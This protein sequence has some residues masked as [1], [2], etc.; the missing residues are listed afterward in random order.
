MKWVPPV[1][2]FGK[3][4]KPAEAPAYPFN[5]SERT[6]FKQEHDDIVSF[7]KYVEGLPCPLC[8]HSELALVSYEKGKQGWEAAVTCNSCQLRGVLNTD[9]FRVA[10]PLFLPEARS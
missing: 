5:T 2:R 3:R 4:Q 7:R 6:L 10:K 1:L 8:A 9:G